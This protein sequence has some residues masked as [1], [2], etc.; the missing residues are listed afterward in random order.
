MTI[1][2]ITD[3]GTFPQSANLDLGKSYVNISQRNAA[4]E[5]YDSSRGFTPAGVDGAG[6]IVVSEFTV[7]P[8][9]VVKGLLDNI[10][11]GKGGADDLV[12][13]LNGE[14]EVNGLQ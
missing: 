2:T 6:N 13:V 10:R 7:P 3:V 11:L 8:S 5:A 12:I 9:G 1:H 4:G 14:F